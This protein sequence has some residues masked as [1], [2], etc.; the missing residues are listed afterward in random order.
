MKKILF[1]LITVA[2]F[3]SSCNKAD[4]FKVT[5]NLS[6]ADQQ[7]VYLC[8]DVDGADVLIDSAVFAGDQAVLKAGYDDPQTCYV[9]KF[10]PSQDCGKFQFFTENQNTTITGDK[11]AIEQWEVKGCATMDDYNAYRQE[12]LSME[13]SMMAL[14]NES[15]EAYISGDTVKAA[16]IFAQVNAAMED[17]QNYRFDYLKNHADSYLTHFLV[18]QGVDEFG[19]EKVKE[20]AE[21]FTAESVYRNRINDYLAEQAKWEV[22]APYIDFTLKTADGQDVNLGTVINYNRVVMVDF[23][24]SWCGPCRGENPFVKAA[25]EKYHAQGLEIIGV[26]VDRDEAAWLKAVADDG[27]TWIQV[28]DVDGVAATDYKVQFIPS[29]FLYNSDGVMIAKGLR[30]EALEAKL[31]EVLQ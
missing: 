5:L 22:G 25:Y 26:S 21:S 19:Y 20:L 23:W 13:A 29:N 15:Q 12:M 18:L 2:L 27:M 24:A 17:Y 6:N 7:T 8:K 4:Q 14:F 30:G 16:E 31:A 3:L 1:T 9:I 11:D 28:R 10:E